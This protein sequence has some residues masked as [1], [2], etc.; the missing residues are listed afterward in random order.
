LIAHL[1]VPQSLTFGA[2][3][4]KK[5]LVPKRVEFLNILQKEQVVENIY[6]CIVSFS[7]HLF[8]AHKI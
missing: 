8:K 5:E 7:K 4:T 1:N 6:L 2:V 3:F